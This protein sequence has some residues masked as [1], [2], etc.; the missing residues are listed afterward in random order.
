MAYA[1]I[2]TGYQPGTYNAVPG[3]AEQSNL[4]DSA[5]MTAYT[6]G[7][8][9]RFLDDRLQVNDE[10]FYYDYEDLLVQSFNLNTALLTTFNAAQTTIWGNQLDVLFLPTG[11]DRLNLSVGYLNAEYDDFIVPA[12]RQHRHPQPR[13]RR[14]PA[15]ERARV[16]GHGRIPARIPGRSGPVLGAHRD[17]LRGFVLGHLRAVPRH[18]A[19][20]LLQVRRVGH[21]LRG[22][23]PLESRPVGE[24]HRERGGAGGDDHGPVRA[25]TPTSFIEPP[26]TWGAR[27]TFKL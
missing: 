4:V 25:R 13:F 27:F 24:E 26:R 7:I 19:A 16:D 12:E 2:Q 14:L 1:T 11:R 18:R 21:V 5:T 6:A 10:I 8:K 20:G 3:D 9:S 17:A 22:R 15:A 23:R